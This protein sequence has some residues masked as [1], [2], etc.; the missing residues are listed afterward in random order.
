MDLVQIR[1]EAKVTPDDR[2]EL[3]TIDSLDSL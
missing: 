3:F 2:T 1:F